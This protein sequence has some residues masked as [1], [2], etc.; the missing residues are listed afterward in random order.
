MRFK[1]DAHPYRGKSLSPAAHKEEGRE[2]EETGITSTPALLRMIKSKNK[3]EKKNIRKAYERRPVRPARPRGG[4]DYCEDVIEQSKEEKEGGEKEDLFEGKKGEWKDHLRALTRVDTFSF[5]P[6]VK[7]KKI[8]E[9]LFRGRL[10]KEVLR[11]GE[12]REGES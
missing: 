2:K 9:A 11:P 1:L 6:E 4:K 8:K 7:K 3:G 10:R 5:R 12:K